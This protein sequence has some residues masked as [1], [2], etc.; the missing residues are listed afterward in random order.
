MLPASERRLVWQSKASRAVSS[1]LI[2]DSCD[3]WSRL[4]A[5]APELGVDVSLSYQTVPRNAQPMTAN[6]CLT[7]D[8]V[9]HLLVRDRVIVREL[10]AAFGEKPPDLIARLKARDPARLSDTA[11]SLYDFLSDA[12]TTPLALIARSRTAEATAISTQ[13]NRWD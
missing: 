3:I 12:S 6:H 11:A 8:D 9:A 13:F 10:A 2:R 5:A 1:R 4:S 7:I